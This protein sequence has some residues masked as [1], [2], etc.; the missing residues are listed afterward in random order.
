MKVLVVGASQI[1][2]PLG[3]EAIAGKAMGDIAVLKDTVIGIEDG[4]ITYVGPRDGAGDFDELIDVT[5]KAVLPGFVDSHT[6]FVFGGYRAEEFAWRMAGKTYMEIM[7]L[8]GGIKNTMDATKLAT[9]QDLMEQSTH[10]LR[11]MVEMG[12]TTVEGKSGYGMDFETEIKQ[13]EVM[14]DLNQALSYIDIVPTFM[15]AHIVPPEYKGRTYEFIDFLLT[16]VMPVVKAQGLSEFCDVFTEKGV[17]SLEESRYLLENAKAQGFKLKMHADEIVP[18]GGAELAAEL[19]CVSA[20]HLL[21]IS[22]KGIEALAASGTVATCLPTTA[23]CLK[24][25]YAP[26]RAMIDGGCAVAMASDVNPGSGFSN[27]VPLMIALG[28]IY[29]QMSMEEVITALTLNGAAAIDRAHEI[30]TIE[31][32]KA[33]DLVV[34]QYDSYQFLSYHTGVNCVERV[35]K[36]GQV[37]VDRR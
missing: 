8:G 13:L 21:H 14:R 2:T 25:A 22:P 35:I 29:M 9:H 4:V 19:S 10:L 1:V 30:G 23:F 20:D 34:L 7:K 26:A 11:E 15:G 33:A 3:K 27:S 17:Y 18:F 31:V 28:V 16:E 37:V 6:H 5:G 12:V 36:G 24:E 32:G